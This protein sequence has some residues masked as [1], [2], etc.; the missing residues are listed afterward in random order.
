MKPEIE[1]KRGDRL[2][3]SS[4]TSWRILGVA[5]RGEFLPASPGAYRQSHRGIEFLRLLP[6]LSGARLKCPTERAFDVPEQLTFE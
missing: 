1:P 4:R 5:T 6:K 2:R 3:Q